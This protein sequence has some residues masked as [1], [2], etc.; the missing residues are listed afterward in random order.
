MADDD[1][2]TA[3]P[4][5]QTLD[6]PAITAFSERI[7]TLP[8]LRP[9]RDDDAVAAR[10]RASALPSRSVLAYLTGMTGDRELMMCGRCILE[11][12]HRTGPLAPAPGVLDDDTR[13]G[14]KRRQNVFLDRIRRRWER[15]VP[16]RERRVLVFEWSSRVV[17]GDGDPIK[18][19][20]DNSLLHVLL[21][22]GYDPARI[23]VASLDLYGLG[24]MHGLDADRAPRIGPVGCPDWFAETTVTRDDDPPPSSS[25]AHGVY[26]DL[27]PEMR[28]AVRRAL[29]VLRGAGVVHFNTV[30]C[31]NHHQ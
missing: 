16:V 6:A 28:P 7:Q 11:G 9:T 12:V 13:I 30:V 14:I 31:L 5:L 26:F 22:F 19:A 21:A 15:T 17:D 1:D 3:T 23:T 18:S 25:P 8:L 24:W 29:A 4:V 10:V 2:T 27:W 20:A